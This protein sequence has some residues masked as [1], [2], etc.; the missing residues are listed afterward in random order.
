MKKYQYDVPEDV[1]EDIFDYHDEFLRMDVP[2]FLPWQGI[3][4]DGVNS[5][6]VIQVSDDG[7]LYRTGSF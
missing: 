2:S 6:T 1:L 3:H 7:E 5:G 4:H